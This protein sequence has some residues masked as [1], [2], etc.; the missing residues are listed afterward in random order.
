MP[1]FKVNVSLVLASGLPFGP[2]NSEPYRNKFNLLSYKRLDI[3]FSAKFFDAEKKNK[4][5]A[6]IKSLWVTL[7]VFNAVDFYNQVSMSWIQDYTGNQFA[8]PN[9]LTGR[10][11][12]GRI[13]VN[14]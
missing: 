7:D 6:M 10:R 13:Q 9:Y 5:K 4:P 1:N 11:I 12:N 14:F 8:V 3:G 2:P